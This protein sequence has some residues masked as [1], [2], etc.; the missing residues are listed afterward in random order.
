M[1]EE[2]F[3]SAQQLTCLTTELDFQILWGQLARVA[4]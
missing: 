4:E 2:L 3:E 1:L